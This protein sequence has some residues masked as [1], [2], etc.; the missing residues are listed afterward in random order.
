MSDYLW[1]KTGDPD[2]ETERLEELLGQL[3]F[4]PRTF[5]VPATLPFT[6]RRATPARAPFNWSRLAVAASLIATLLF[7]AWLIVSKQR[8][9]N[10]PQ[11]ARQPATEEKATQ[12]PTDQEVAITIPNNGVTTRAR[13]DEHEIVDRVVAPIVHR[14][15]RAA[16]LVASQKRF[17]GPPRHSNERNLNAPHG[18]LATNATMTPTER[19]AMEKFMLAMKVT[20]E[21]LGYAERQ[22]AGLGH[23]SP[24]R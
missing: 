14:R 17:I 15:Q 23:D 19:E 11:L 8:T 2:A 7:G 24:Q 22:V 9:V 4:Q 13:K 18:E 3:R 12:Q 20:S 21:K 16:T 10:T 5:E 1:D 6:P